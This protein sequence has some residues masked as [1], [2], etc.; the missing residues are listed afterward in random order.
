MPTSK[1]LEDIA[2]KIKAATDLWELHAALIEFETSA[3]G[4]TDEDGTPSFEDVDTESLLKYHG[5]DICELDT[6]G[7]DTPRSTDGVWSWD[8]CWL[9]AGEGPFKDWEIRSR[10]AEA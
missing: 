2:V 7:G 8:P 3:K 1:K 10:F 5:I 4:A 9:L 6:F